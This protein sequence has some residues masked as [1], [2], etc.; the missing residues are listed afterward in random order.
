M[1]V[2]QR[3]FYNPAGLLYNKKFMGKGIFTVM[4]AR[5]CAGTGCGG[6]PG[7]VPAQAGIQT[8][9]NISG[10]PLSRE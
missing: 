10:F 6:H 7:L 2:C 4:P 3:N 1:F 5:A 8:K 9:N